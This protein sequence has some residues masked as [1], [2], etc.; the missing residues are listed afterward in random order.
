MAERRSK[1]QPN[2]DVFFGERGSYQLYLQGRLVEH[3]GSPQ[4]DAFGFP[5]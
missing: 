3:F 1:G 2:R 5:R 4:I